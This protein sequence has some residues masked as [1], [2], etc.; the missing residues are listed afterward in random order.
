MPRNGK[1]F[2]KIKP[3]AGEQLKC[4]DPI[5]SMLSLAGFEEL[6]PNQTAH[7]L[8]RNLHPGDKVAITSRYND[9]PS[10]QPYVDALIDRGIR[11]RVITGQTGVE[12]FCF[13][14][15][16][17]KELV[18]IAESTYAT[19]AAHL[20][21]AKRARFYSMDSQSRRR[22]PVFSERVFFHYNWTNPIL[23]KKEY[24]ELYQA[25]ES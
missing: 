23:K 16:A 15:H 10:V 6:S 20:G 19:W 7:G 1:R 13:L 11:V 3:V 14:M 12:D 24:F 25:E 21:N 2:G 4:R 18:G 22:S 5:Q 17:Q 8:F 9:H